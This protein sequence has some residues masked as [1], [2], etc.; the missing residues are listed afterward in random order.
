M[1]EQG[2]AIGI[3]GLGHAVP[4]T[5][6]KN[7]DPL[8]RDAGLP[9]DE[10]LFIGF[11]ERR[12]LAPGERLEDLG[13]LAAR[14]ALA[15]AGAGAD[16]IDGLYG[17]VSPGE[18]MLPSGLFA[19][20]E[21]LALGRETK[22]VPI[23]SEFT[24]FVDA[25]VCAC[26]AVAAGRVRRALVVVAAGWS[27]LVD[28]ADAGAAGIGDGAGAVVV[29]RGA[30]WELVD[31]AS[32][33][34]GAWRGAMTLQM[35][36]ARRSP[37]GVN[38]GPRPLFVFEAEAARA[39]RELGLAVPERLFRKLLERGGLAPAEV[40]LVGHQPSSALLDAWRGLLG[41][42]VLPSVLRE[43]GNCTLATAAITLS[44][45]A[46][47]LGPRHVVLLGMG[48]G[49]NFSAALLRRHGTSTG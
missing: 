18:V 42:G 6:R 29:A 12:V 22:V 40:A 21:A 44:I 23:Q 38:D 17:A 31:E 4:D 49:Q 24:N 11:D 14:R 5:I 15:D 46:R 32:E 26:D 3:V 9:S 35:R 20:H 27:R 13:V 43:L 41:V 10:G 33:T 37:P 36:A 39:F 28:Y 16:E 47:T 7:D 45:H 2:S 48:L 30:R 25:L 34:H 8:F 1:K 19:I